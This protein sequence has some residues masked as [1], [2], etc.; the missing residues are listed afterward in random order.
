M[1]GLLGSFLFGAGL[2]FAGAFTWEAVRARR[3]SAAQD[4]A[5]G[6]GKQARRAMRV[7]RRERQFDLNTA[8]LDELRGLGLDADAVDR[9]IEH[10]P[11]RNKLDLVSQLVLPREEYDRIKHSLRVTRSTDGVKVA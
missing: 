10:R 8:S 4:R 6:A 5:M 1:K 2:A 11:Y 7:T 9:V 3:E